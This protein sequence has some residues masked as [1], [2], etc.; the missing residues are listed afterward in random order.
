MNMQLTNAR[1]E[2]LIVCIHKYKLLIC[3]GFLLLFFFWGGGGGGGGGVA[4][5][6]MP[7]F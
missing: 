1:I 7:F 3:F 5:V 2:F 4:A 6:F